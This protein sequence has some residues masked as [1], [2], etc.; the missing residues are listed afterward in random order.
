M[1]ISCEECGAGLDSIR[2][3]TCAVCGVPLC[4]DCAI[5]A[6]QVSKNLCS[7]C[8]AIGQEHISCILQCNEVHATAV[9]YLIDNWKKASTLKKREDIENAI[10]DV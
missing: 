2:H 1:K 4:I 6:Q 10:S 3:W 9:Q 7:A 5:Y 8:D